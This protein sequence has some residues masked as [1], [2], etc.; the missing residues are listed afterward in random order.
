MSDTLYDNFEEINAPSETLDT[1]IFSKGYPKELGIK[2]NPKNNPVM[3]FF[4]LNDS[5][6]LRINATVDFHEC[7]YYSSYPGVLASTQ[8]QSVYD[9]I[10]A[11]DA[12]WVEE[13]ENTK[14]VG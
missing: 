11:A 3:D 10:V 2:L 8:C 5:T 12:Q 6:I 13:V 1:L 9:S 14:A 7:Y 4:E